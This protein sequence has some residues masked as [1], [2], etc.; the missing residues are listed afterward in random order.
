[1]SDRDSTVHIQSQQNTTPRNKRN[2]NP[3]TFFCE[4]VQLLSCRTC[5]IEHLYQCFVN[6]R[7]KFSANTPDVVVG[8]EDFRQVFM[9]GSYLLCDA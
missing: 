7:K 6:F 1:M 3:F 4:K 8:N 2:I 9:V 5:Y